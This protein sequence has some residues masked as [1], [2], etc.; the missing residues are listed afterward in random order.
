[1]NTV[2]DVEE[3]L[4]DFIRA[5]ISSFSPEMSSEPID[6]DPLGAAFYSLL[7]SRYNYSDI[8]I[9]SLRDGL[10]SW[11]FEK[12]SSGNFSPYIDRDMTAL[13]LAA[14]SFEVAGESILDSA[15]I[16][17][18]AEL[19]TPHY[20]ETTGFF[21]DLFDTA[22]IATC[23]QRNHPHREITKKC[24]ALLRKKFH[25]AKPVIYN[26]AKTVYAYFILASELKDRRLQRQLALESFELME[27]KPQIEDPQG[28]IYLSLVAIEG[29]DLMDR[30]HRARAKAIF[31]S[32]F[33]ILRALSSRPPVDHELASTYGRDLGRPSRIL[34]TAAQ[35]FADK[36]RTTPFQWYEKDASKSVLR[37]IIHIAGISILFVSLVY[38]LH[39]FGVAPL[40]AKRVADI[41]W[42]EWLRDAALIATLVVNLTYSQ[43]FILYFVACGKLFHNLVWL[44]N[45]E[46]WVYPA[47][48]DFYKSKLLWDLLIG[49]VATFIGSGILS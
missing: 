22:I 5:D 18:L 36:F 47:A 13:C 15:S 9:A 26:D 30:S 29:F 10:K 16:D 1:M 48:W 17:R 20:K 28:R 38:S 46:D 8:Y 41:V 49:L 43:L 12:L 23:L 33:D 2:A 4:R 42:G 34:L 44:R 35:A 40:P 6:Q 45:G 25:E 14:Y 39:R 37:G 19:I 27:S 31:L 7:S 32:S 24:V 21:S 3:T 11:V